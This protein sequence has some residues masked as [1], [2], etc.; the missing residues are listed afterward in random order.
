MGPELNEVDA[1]RNSCHRATDEGMYAAT[2]SGT[3]PDLSK[4]SFNSVPQRDIRCRSEVSRVVG[5]VVGHAREPRE[6]PTTTARLSSQMT[7][8][9]GFEMRRRFSVRLKFEF[10]K[11]KLRRVVQPKRRK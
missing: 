5:S 10:P 11:R 6:I 8:T 2:Q 4:S 3:E 1:L 9:M 7:K